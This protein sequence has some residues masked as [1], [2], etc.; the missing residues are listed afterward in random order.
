MA[1][2]FEM[3][4]YWTSNRSRFQWRC[5]MRLTS[6]LVVLAAGLATCLLAIPGTA[7]DEKL[8]PPTRAQMVASENNLKQIGLAFHNH[9]AAFRIFPNNIYSKDGKGLLSWRVHILQFVEQ[10]VLYK[11]FNLDE[12]WDS[13]TNKPLVAKMPKLYAPIRVKAKEGETFYRGFA[14]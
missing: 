4:S 7:A 12:P 5:A 9:E 13:D 14:G 3:M 8:A 10:E 1:S 11:Q 2:P 6:V